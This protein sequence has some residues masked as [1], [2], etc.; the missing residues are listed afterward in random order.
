MATFLHRAIN[1][2]PSVSDGDCNFSDHSDLVRSAV[3]QVHTSDSIGTAF[4]VG[5]DEWLTAAHVVTGERT[6]TLRNGTHEL[7]AAVIGGNNSADIALLEAASPATPLQ[8]GR[9]TDTKPG[10]P[11]YVVG[12]PL[13]VA[14]DPSV[15][16]GILSR[17]EERSDLGTTLVTDAASNPGNSGG[18]VVDDCGNVLGMLV[19]GYIDFEGVNLAIAESTLQERLPAIHDG[20]ADT[21]AETSQPTAQQP[22][23]PSDWEPSNGDKWI[24]VVTYRDVNPNSLQVDLLSM[25][26]SC[27]SSL[28]LIVNFYLPSDTTWLNPTY[29]FVIDYGFGT[30]QQIAAWSDLG[31]QDGVGPSSIY[32]DGGALP[33][34]VRE[35]RSDTSGVLYLDFF[36][37]W[38]AAFG[39]DFDYDHEGGGWVG[40]R[41]VAED[42][43][44]VLRA[45]G[46]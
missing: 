15:T 2:T 44:P 8:F 31:W 30:P 6:V 37:A 27:H 21:P 33:E 1:R 17:V 24:G 11:L 41:G 19:A 12:F 13:Y 26:V 34:F 5:H 29:G 18:P 10:D 38:D 32:M 22:A 35:L 25:Y 28:G 23:G 39:D 9:L 14:S 7:E 42:V 43:E 40:V 36:S 3:Y 4:Y 45:C 46:F 16:R 20:W